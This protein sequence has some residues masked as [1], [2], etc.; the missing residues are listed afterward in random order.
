[1]CRR[2]IYSSSSSWGSQRIR[3]LSHALR[4]HL[5]LPPGYQN[6][7]KLKRKTDL[8]LA[9]LFDCAAQF[10]AQLV[11][12]GE[13]RYEIAQFQPG[14]ILDPDFMRIQGSGETDDTSA[15]SKNGP[16]RRIR[17]CIHGCLVALL[18][19]AAGEPVRRII[20]CNKAL[21]ILE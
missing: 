5:H 19:E 15:P 14:D 16:V 3:S 7:E 8:G 2:V 17:L 11:H 20:Q 10:R 9:L 13:F 4:K 12:C 18:E 6:C 21:V 1:M